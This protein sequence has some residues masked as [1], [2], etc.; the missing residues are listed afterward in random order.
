MSQPCATLNTVKVAQDAD[1]DL[2]ALLERGALIW[3][4]YSLLQIACAGVILDQDVVPAQIIA[5]AVPYPAGHPH[6][7]FYSRIFNLSN[8][9]GAVLWRIESGPWLLSFIRNF[10]FL[11]LSAYVPYAATVVLLPSAALATF[12]T[13]LTLSGAMLPAT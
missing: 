12:A 10:L 4:A 8:Y 5:H 6:E 9:L 7:V 1:G 11:F 2:R 13:A 3:A